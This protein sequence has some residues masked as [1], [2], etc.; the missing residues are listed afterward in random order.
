MCDYITS[1]RNAVIS[2]IDR[3]KFVEKL[4]NDASARPPNM[5]SVSCDFDFLMA[6]LNRFTPLPHGR[7][8]LASEVALNIMPP[9]ASLARQRHKEHR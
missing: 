2:Q 5:S 8:K 4:E 9:S 3:L 6:K 7:T 1:T